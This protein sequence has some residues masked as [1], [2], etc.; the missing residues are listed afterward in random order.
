MTG[1]RAQTV[2]VLR[3]WMQYREAGTGPPVLLPHGNPTSS[4]LWR[5]VLERVGREDGAGHRWIAPEAS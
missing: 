4:L 1:T 5:H 2:R 3:S